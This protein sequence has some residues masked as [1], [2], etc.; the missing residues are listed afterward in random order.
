ME[1][2]LVVIAGP[3]TGRTFALHDGQTLVIGRGQASDTQ[4]ADAAMSRVHCRVVVA[5]DK[6]TLVDAGSSSGT[7]MGNQKIDQQELRA[8]DVFRVGD[9]Q[10]RFEAHRPQ[11]STTLVRDRTAPAPVAQGLEK[12]LGQSL[13]NYRLDSVIARGSGGMVFKGTDTQNNKPVAVKVLTPDPTHSEEQKERFVRAMKT[14]LPIKHPNIVQLYNAG[15]T[16]P[17]CWSAMEY[18]DGESMTQVIQR[19]GIEGMLDWREVWRVAV[20]IGRAL[21]EAFHN[22]IVHRNVT[23]ANILRRKADKVCLLGDLILAKALEGTLARQVTQQGEIVG[24]VAY[25][26][27]ERILDSSRADSRSDMYSLGATLY[28][29]LTGRAPFESKSLV[30][31]M[32]MIREAEPVRPKKYQLAIDDLFQDLVMKLLAKRPE[33]RFQTPIEMLRDLNRIGTFKSLSADP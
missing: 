20:H 28:A 15:K 8:G 12:L 25:L 31:L 18:V 14:M 22:K 4:I 6:V 3:E 1:R 33:D 2:Q 10:F 30:E 16:G 7:L 27:P 32:R 19:I 29:L 17:Y 21:E 11:E 24:D 26:A 23:P 13:A 9:T 5:G